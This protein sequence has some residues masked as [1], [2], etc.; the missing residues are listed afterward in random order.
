MSEAGGSRSETHSKYSCFGWGCISFFVNRDEPSRHTVKDP[1]QANQGEQSK[2]GGR[3]RINVGGTIFETTVSTLTRLN[4]TML[5]ALVSNRWNQSNQEE[6]FVDRNPTYFGKV[7]DYLR[8]GENFAV[9]T[10]HD[11]RECLRREA[12]FYN[13]SELA[14]MCSP[15]LHVGDWVMWKEDAVEAKWKFFARDVD[16][17]SNMINYEEWKHVKHEMRFMKGIVTKV[18]SR[19]CCT[20][21]WDNDW[22]FHERQS[23]LRLAT[24]Q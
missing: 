18:K 14:K 15:G 23:A 3:L 9:P 16:T 20:V 21:K 8:D 17:H 7:L 4:D 1:S 24:S 10:D 6:I 5:S 13:L 19:M 11:V 12:D 22:K 2:T